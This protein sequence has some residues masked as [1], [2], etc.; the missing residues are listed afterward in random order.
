MEH[1]IG[2]KSESDYRSTAGLSPDNASL[3][4][5]TSGTTP[6]ARAFLLNGE[7]P[8]ARA[9]AR[10]ATKAR[11]KLLILAVATVWATRQTAAG[12]GRPAIKPVAG[13]Y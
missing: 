2:P 1:F 12:A 8:K 9:G 10:K 6:K 4:K 5:L 7:G 13:S 11:P 3:N